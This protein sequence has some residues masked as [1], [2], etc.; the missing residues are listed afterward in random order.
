MVADTVPQTN[1]TQ[2]VPPPFTTT[3]P[4]AINAIETVTL[5]SAHL[6]L[7]RISPPPLDISVPETPKL[8]LPP[9]QL[10]PPPPPSTLP[11]PGTTH[12]T[13]SL[14]EKLGRGRARLVYAVTVSSDSDAGGLIRE[15]A[16]YTRLECVQGIAVPLCYGAFEGRLDE[17][18]SLGIDPVWTR[19]RDDENAR[20]I[21][22]LPADREERVTPERRRR[23]AAEQGD[24]MYDM[25]EDL[26]ALQILHINIRYANILS[27]GPSTA[28]SICPWHGYAHKYRIYDFEAARLYAAT[29]QYFGPHFTGWY[30]MESIL[31]GLPEGHIVEISNI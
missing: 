9:G 26:A 31:D 7:R 21:E 4:I 16:V 18:C 24:D 2:P 12:I 27:S 20:Y 25:Y 11:P 29:E 1:E 28:S 22:R 15:A 10:P 23:D 19:Y 14:G 13:I 17:G 30:F 6:T 8:R 5:Q 3:S